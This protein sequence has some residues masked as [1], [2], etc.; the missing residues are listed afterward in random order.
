MYHCK[1]TPLFWTLT[2]TI[3]YMANSSIHSHIPQCPH[4][5]DDRSY[6]LPVPAP[7]PTWVAPP[8]P[9]VATL[10]ARDPYLH[11]IKSNTLTYIGVFINRFLGTSKRI[12]PLQHKVL[13][14][15][16]HSIDMVF[17]PLN[18]QGCPSKKEKIS[19]KNIDSGKFC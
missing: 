4:L 1:D 12:I 17:N 10:S 8:I 3:V 5:R 18:R 16:L 2:E 6:A 7:K 14:E 11:K 19:L 13:W 9:C 15:L